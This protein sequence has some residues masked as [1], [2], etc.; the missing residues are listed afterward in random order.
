MPHTLSLALLLGGRVATPAIL[1]S[2]G[3]AG[4][5]NYPSRPELPRTAGLA[6]P[7]PSNSETQCVRGCRGASQQSPVTDIT[8]DRHSGAARVEVDLNRQGSYLY[9][10]LADD[11]RGF[12][13]T[14]EY[15]GRGLRSMQSRAGALGGKVRWESSPGAGSR[16]WITVRLAPVKPLSALRGK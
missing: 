15:E 14:V 2:S 1:G 13:T 9:L 5:R 11:G 3:H 16:V 12:D 7:Q 4:G 8:P 6:T 10:S